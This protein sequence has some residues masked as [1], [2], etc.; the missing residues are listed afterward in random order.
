[1]INFGN[2][3]KYK[4]KFKRTDNLIV[5]SVLTCINENEAEE[6]LKSIPETLFLEMVSC[7]KVDDCEDCKL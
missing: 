1:M 6:I 7:E 4:A 3:I 5:S 2:P